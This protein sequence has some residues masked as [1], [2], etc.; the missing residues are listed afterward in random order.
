[1]SSDAPA[2]DSVYKLVAYDGRG[3]RKTSEGKATWPGAKQ[4]WRTD[5]WRGD[6]LALRDETA[7]VPGAVPLLATV[8]E[9]GRRIADTSLEA[10]HD[11]FER[12]WAMMPVALKDLTEPVAYDVEPSDALQQLT[13]AVDAE[14]VHRTEDGQA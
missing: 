2:L 6:V 14:H 12:Q 11:A 9:A 10:A 3:V 4:V 1:V 8:M 5:G 13:A 7:P